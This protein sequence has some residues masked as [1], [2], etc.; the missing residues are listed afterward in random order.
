MSSVQF[1]DEIEEF[2]S[3]ESMRHWWNNGVHEKCLS[4][5]SFFVRCNIPER[6]GLV[7]SATWQDSIHQ[8]L[9]RIPASISSKGLNTH[10]CSIDSKLSAYEAKL[11]AYEGS[12]MLEL[13]IWKSEIAEQTDGNINL[14]TPDMKMGCRIDSLWM[15]DIILPN[16]LS[17]L[18]GDAFEG[19]NGDDGD[20]DGDDDD[21][22]EDDEDDD[23][24]NDN[25]DRDV[26]D[27]YINDEY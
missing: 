27:G 7:R 4:T 20:G 6:V 2:L 3:G 26:D 17:F 21:N 19:D 9:G 13:A 18:R 24:G 5:Y 25:D 10:L 14:V 8:M 1:C 15:V 22:E 23:Y 16:V 12:T 11:S